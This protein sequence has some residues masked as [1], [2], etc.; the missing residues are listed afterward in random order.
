M[1]IDLA[2]LAVTL[3]DDRAAT[4]FERIEEQIDAR[5]VMMDD[6]TPEYAQTNAW[7]ELLRIEH[8]RLLAKEVEQR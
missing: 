1:D 3:A 5:L 7:L 6:E 2:G 8:S 4:A